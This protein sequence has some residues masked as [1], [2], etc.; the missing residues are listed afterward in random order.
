ME[1]ESK[2]FTRKPDSCYM[3]P[4]AR[5]AKPSRLKMGRPRGI[6]SLTRIISL[7]VRDDEIETY[8][9]EAIE[10]NRP[11][12]Q[13]LVMKLRGEIPL[14]KSLQTKRVAGKVKRAAPMRVA[15]E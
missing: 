6:K 1:T 3:D 8:V 13:L 2:I 14:T 11:L 5:I 4:M 9:D 12:G 7:R 15:A 10:T